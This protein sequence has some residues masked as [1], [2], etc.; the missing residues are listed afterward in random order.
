MTFNKTRYLR[1]YQFTYNVNLNILM[2]L[3]LIYNP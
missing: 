3:T 1:K 2:P